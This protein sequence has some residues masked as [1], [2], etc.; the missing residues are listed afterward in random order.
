MIIAVRTIVFFLFACCLVTNANADESRPAHLQLKLTESDSV[1]MVFKVPALGDRRLSLYPKMPDN[2]TTVSPPTAQI[3][4]NAYTERATFRCTGGLVGETVTI[5]GLSG[6]LTDVLARVTRSDGAT[7]VARL[8]PST[9]SF[10]VEATPDALAVVRSYLLFGFAHILSGSDHLLFVL[11]LLI[12]VPSIRVLVWTITA[13]TIAHSLT[14]AAAALG[15]V[16]FPQPP[17]EAVIALSIVFVAS[18]IIH[19][20]QGRPGLTQRRPW[21]VAFTFGLLHGLGFAGALTE[22]GLPEQ[23]IPL[24]LLFFNVGVELGQLAFVAAILLVMVLSKRLLRETPMWMPTATAYVIGIVA[25]YWTI[26]RVLG[27]W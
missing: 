14:L 20:S 5:E 15:F 8:T 7:Q 6:T 17:V 2:C 1:T 19:V 9:P 24:A 4:D 16:S 11:A 23:A 21:V 12:L 25:S 3:I 10:I 18:E 27:F 13:F 26:E 22:V